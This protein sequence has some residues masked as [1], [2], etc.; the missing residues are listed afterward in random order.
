MDN[1]FWVFAH[2][3][4]YPSG[5]TSDLRGRFNTLEEAAELAKTL[6]YDSVYVTDVATGDEVFDW[7]ILN[8]ERIK[9]MLD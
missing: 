5:G 3:D 1:Q 4:Y 2:D 8:S 9:A 7:S 6:T